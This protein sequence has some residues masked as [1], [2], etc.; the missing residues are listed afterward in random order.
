MSLF[1]EIFIWWH[2]QTMGTR[3]Y[4]WRK[5][6][7]VGKDEQ[8]NRYYISNDGTDRRWVLYNGVAEA[9]RVTPDWHGWLHH[10]VDVAPTEENY[11]PRAWQKPHIP[12]MTGTPYAYRPQGSLHRGGTR[13]PATGDYE[14]WRPE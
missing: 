10:T 7:L 14:A 6:K 5:G 3:F 1:S 12:N 9:S 11:T 4:T 2:G 13:P 8:G